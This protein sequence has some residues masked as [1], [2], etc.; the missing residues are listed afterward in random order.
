MKYYIVER[1]AL[2]KNVKTAVNKARLDAEHILQRNNYKGID[3]IIPYTDSKKISDLIKEQVSNYKKWKRELGI[4]KSG[5]ILFI[6]FP[7]KAHSIFYNNLFRKLKKNNVKVIFLIHDL[8]LLRNNKGHNIT[9]KRRIRTFFE[10]TILLKS[11]DCIIS[12]NQ[13]MT[14]FLRNNGFADTLI[15]NLGLFDYL[16][17]E[18]FKETEKSKDEPLIIAGNLRPKKA[19]YLQQLDQLGKT[20]FNLYGIGFED[21][22]ISNISYNGSF[23]P[24]EL[25]YYLRGG[26]GLVWDGGSID[27]CADEI[28]SYL[29]YNNPHKASLYL[30]SGFP[31]AV[32]SESALSDLIKELNVGVSGNSLSEI[33]AKIENL[34]E[35][36]YADMKSNVTA[37]AGK[38]KTGGYLSAALHEAENLLHI[39]N[40]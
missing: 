8:D 26:F 5:D 37:L 6:Q 31:V 29:R 18:D 27:T 20:K 35:E 28:G 13:R 10:E 33:T 30:A 2:E 19:G 36:E 16:I 9:V 40:D 38:L 24:D 4:L 14:N 21:N 3:I 17:D 12:H 11:A 15:V 34:S 39:K 22:G 25:P 32:W 1:P 7:L 23:M